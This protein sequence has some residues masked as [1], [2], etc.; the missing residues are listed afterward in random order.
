MTGK[1]QR[2][3]IWLLLGV[4]YCGVPHPVARVPLAPL[5]GSGS[6]P[7]AAYADWVRAKWRIGRSRVRFNRSN[8]GKPS[9]FMQPRPAPEP[10]PLT[11]WQRL[12]TW[13]KGQ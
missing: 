11:G 3:R 8:A 1:R 12:R 2:P 13:L 10:E 4:W 5:F 6:T 7:A 9:R